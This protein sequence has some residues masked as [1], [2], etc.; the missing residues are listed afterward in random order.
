M[1]QRK[2]L[3]ILVLLVPQIIELI[4]KKNNVDEISANKIFYNSNTYNILQD[5]ES[6]L[7]HLS[8]LTIYGLFNQEETIGK[9]N[10]PEEC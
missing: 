3:T 2:F 9:I 1:N 4:V 8:P 6:K 7:W 5:E 10:F